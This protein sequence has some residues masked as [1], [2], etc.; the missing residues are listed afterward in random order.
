V[1]E[2]GVAVGIAP[3]VPDAW[4]LNDRALRS[5]DEG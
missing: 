3:A 2:A 1:V 4:V 5:L